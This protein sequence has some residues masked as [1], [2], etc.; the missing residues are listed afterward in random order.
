[1]KQKFLI[2]GFL[3]LLA[4]FGL[5]FP[6]KIFGAW[7]YQRT[8]ANFTI[9][10][11]ISF[12]ASND[13]PPCDTWWGFQLYNDAGGYIYSPQ[14]PVAQTSATW[15]ATL[16]IDKYTAVRLTGDNCSPLSFFEAYNSEGIFEVVEAPMPFTMF[17]I[18]YASFATDSLG[19]VGQLFT[20]AWVIIAL[21]IGLPVAF[22]VVRRVIALGHAK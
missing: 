5:F 12:Y 9:S 11:P 2:F 10:N 3:G 17:T 7:D 1:M 18:D 22:Y 19:Y 15:E 14:Y 20:D 6:T 8:P 4:C 21:V 16:P 13:Y